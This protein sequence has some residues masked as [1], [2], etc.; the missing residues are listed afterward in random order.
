[1]IITFTQRF[2]NGL[3]LLLV[4]KKVFVLLSEIVSAVAI[5]IHQ[6]LQLPLFLNFS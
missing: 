3:S 4:N 2:K 1:M 6:V 5:I